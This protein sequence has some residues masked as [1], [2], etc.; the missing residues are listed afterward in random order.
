MY[1]HMHMHAIDIDFRRDRDIDIIELIVCDN[2]VLSP[3]LS[4]LQLTIDDSIKFCILIFC[5]TSVP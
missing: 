5:H 1:M 2:A 3:A 4:S